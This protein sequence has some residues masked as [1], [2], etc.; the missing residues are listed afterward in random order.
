MGIFDRIAQSIFSRQLRSWTGVT[1]TGD[2]LDRAL[3]CVEVFQI[4]SRR[5]PRPH[6]NPLVRE[7]ARSLVEEAQA[8]DGGLEVGLLNFEAYYRLPFGQPCVPTEFGELDPKNVGPKL[9]SDSTKE[10]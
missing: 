9:R 6:R 1:L 2:D 7:C 10:L 3:S 4:W 8:F 5:L